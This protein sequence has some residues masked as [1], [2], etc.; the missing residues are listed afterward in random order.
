MSDGLV[1]RCAW[2][3]FTKGIVGGKT[4]NRNRH[5]LYLGG[6]LRFACGWTNIMA[7]KIDSGIEKEARWF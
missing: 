4:K 5:S 7:M 6:G 1:G 3:T 2:P